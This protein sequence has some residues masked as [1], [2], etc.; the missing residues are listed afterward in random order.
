MRIVYMGT[1]RFAVPALARLLATPRFEVAAVVTQP[2]RPRGRSLQMQPCPVKE[3]AVQHGRAVLTPDKIGEAESELR[4][5][6][7]DVIAVAAYGQFIPRAIRELP[8]LGCINIHPSLL[9]RYRG[10]A[11]MQWAIANGDAVSG[12]TIMHVAKTMDAG[13][14]ILQREY[15]ILPEESAAELEPRFAEIGA[16]MLVEA[17]DLLAAGNAPRIPQNESMVTLARKLSKDDARIDW[18]QPAAVL[19]HR[20]RGYQP[21]PG[22]VCE[23]PKGAGRMLKILRAVVVDGRGEPGTLLD[24]GRDG[25]LVACGEQALRLITVQPENGGAMAATAW[26]NGSRLKPGDQLG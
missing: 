16:G 10:A 6:H 12:V 20:I 25:P 21:W 14:I 22:A 7:P 23:A 19:G 15:P 2:D 4:A 13:D 3:L 26:L 11:P 8:R 1:P 24:A 9:P 17:I 18:V 5:L